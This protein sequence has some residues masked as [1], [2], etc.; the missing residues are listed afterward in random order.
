MRVEQ[1]VAPRAALHL[2][3]HRTLMILCELEQEHSKPSKQVRNH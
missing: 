2:C 1:P 3:E